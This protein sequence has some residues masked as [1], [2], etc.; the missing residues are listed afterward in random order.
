VRRLLSGVPGLVSYDLLRT[1][2]GGA[3]ITV[4]RDQAGTDE[5]LMRARAW[6]QDN[7]TH[8]SPQTTIHEGPVELHIGTQESGRQPVRHTEHTVG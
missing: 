3:T 8:L 1:A 7:A 4:C 6:L 5:S 2:E